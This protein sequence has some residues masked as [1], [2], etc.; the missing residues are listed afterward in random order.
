VQG[1]HR[2]RARRAQAR[3]R[4]RVAILSKGIEGFL[5]QECVGAKTSTLSCVSEIVARSACKNSV[6]RELKS[7]KLRRDRPSRLLMVRRE[8]VV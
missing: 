4:L 2:S 7:K 8:G 5:L 3:R 6:L 1:W